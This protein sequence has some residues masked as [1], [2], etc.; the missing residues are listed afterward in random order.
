[1][2]SF[3]E[4]LRDLSLVE[5]ADIIQTKFAQKLANRRGM[6]KVPTKIPV[7]PTDQ[8][9]FL[10]FETEDGPKRSYIYGVR[11]DGRKEKISVGSK[12]VTDLFAQIYNSGGY[13]D[14]DIQK[15][16]LKD[17]FTES[18]IVASD[19]IIDEKESIIKYQ[20]AKDKAANFRHAERQKKYYEQFISKLTQGIAGAKPYD[21]GEGGPSGVRIK[22]QTGRIDTKI[23]ERKGDA[24]AISDYLGGAI[25]VK[26]LKAMKSI[27]DRIKNSEHKILEIDNMLSGKD[28]D[29]GYRAVHLQVQLKDGF[30]AELQLLPE[31]I[32]RIKEQLHPIYAKYRTPEAEERATYD[33]EFKTKM[34]DTHEKLTHAYAKAFEQFKQF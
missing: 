1:M 18:K 23:E 4:I 25:E 30:S 20:T 14:R 2:K 21:K 10:R 6:Y 22:K 16:N 7:S 13:T 8:T 9:P 28:K 5:D 26:S 31:G 29:E 12:E 19:R 24:S 33:L 34:E 27:L 17:K 15:I 32:A 11:P 3:Y